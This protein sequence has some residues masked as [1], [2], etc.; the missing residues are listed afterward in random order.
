[1]SPTQCEVWVG[2]QILTR[3][4]QAAADAAG[5]PVEQVVVHNQ[6]PGGGFGRRLDVDSI[7]QAV[8][9]ARQA[10]WPVK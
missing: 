5:L 4:Q 10:R 1:M 9:I 8:L 7:T 3:A 2:T 6:L